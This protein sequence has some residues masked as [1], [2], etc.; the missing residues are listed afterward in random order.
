M[1]GAPLT[2]EIEARKAVEK[3]R[4]NFIL[5]LGLWKW[6]AVTEYGTPKMKVFLI[7][8]IYRPTETTKMPRVIRIR[9]AKLA[10]PSVE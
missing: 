8:T 5:R 6:F 10:A 2:K 7:A 9:V 4:V 1:T 3:M